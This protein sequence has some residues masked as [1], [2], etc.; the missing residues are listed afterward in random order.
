MLQNSD[1]AALDNE[2][3][4][5]FLVTGNCSNGLFAHPTE[6]ALAEEFVNLQGRGGIAAWSATGLGFTSW[7]QT[8][9]DWLYET[10]FGNETYQLG[11]A[12]TAAKVATFAQL[13]WR[14]PLEI[15]TLF[16]DPALTLHIVPL[17]LRLSKTGASHIQPGQLL[18]Y[19]LTYINYSN[20]QA[21]NVVLTESYDG[22]TI[23]QAANPAPTSGNNIWQI[24]SLPA[25]AASTITVT[26]QVPE[27]VP[28]GVRLMNQAVLTG[29]N[30]NPAGAT[31]RTFVG[32]PLYLPLIFRGVSSNN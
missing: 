32:H 13:G 11:P 12:T 23:Y 30:F 22:Q 27:T 20:Q 26:V 29:D 9:V 8:L 17:G 16:G 28:K 2:L 10:M 18:T 4:Y 21:D 25:G 5:P 31:V 24:G 6:A 19:T 15:F 3:F 14:E 7:H 1:L